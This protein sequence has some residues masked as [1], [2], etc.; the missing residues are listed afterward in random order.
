MKGTWKL[1]LRMMLASIVMFVMMYI[2]V[3][4]VCTLAGVSMAPMV[5]LAISLVITFI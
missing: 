2:V 5:W 1:H 4:L 3:G